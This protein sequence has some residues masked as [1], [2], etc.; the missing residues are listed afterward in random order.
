MICSGNVLRCGVSGYHVSACSRFKSFWTLDNTSLF[1]LETANECA[2]AFKDG[3]PVIDLDPAAVRDKG[4]G[5]GHC[6]NGAGVEDTFCEAAKLRDL[7]RAC[8]A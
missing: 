3:F 6:E 4:R 1:D 5:R 8:Q 2:D 7:G